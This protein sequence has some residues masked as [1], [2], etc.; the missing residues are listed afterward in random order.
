MGAVTAKRA[1]RAVAVALIAIVM[2]TGL[3][4]LVHLACRVPTN[5]S[6][7]PS[8]RTRAAWSRTRPSSTRAT[9]GGES[10]ATRERNC[11]TT[12]A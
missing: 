9:R 10:T 6:F 12:C 5:G 8:S 3:Y 1:P 2:V 7:S 11:P 4:L